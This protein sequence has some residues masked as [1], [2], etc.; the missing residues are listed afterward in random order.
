MDREAELGHS[1][2]EP[3]RPTGDSGA[4]ERCTHGLWCHKQP[5]GEGQVVRLTLEEVSQWV[6]K[7]PF[8]AF[9]LPPPTPPWKM[10]SNHIVFT[11]ICKLL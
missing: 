11:R 3:G 2:P 8:K 5:P 1:L 9:R 10:C 7:G 4:C 6:P